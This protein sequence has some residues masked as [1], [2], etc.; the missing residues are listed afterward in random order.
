MRLLKFVLA[1]I[2]AVVAVIAGL[3]AAAIAALIAL[4]VF[5]SRRFFR[6]PGSLGGPASA[7]RKH[8]PARFGDV[9]DITATE[10]PP[11]TPRH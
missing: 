5:A 3:F 2:V 11:D 4:A 10:V 8:S 9:I 6:P 7:R 1:G